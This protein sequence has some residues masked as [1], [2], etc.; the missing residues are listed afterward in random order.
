MLCLI[1]TEIV[2]YFGEKCVVGGVEASVCPVFK[3]LGFECADVYSFGDIV[4]R[5]L[6]ERGD[7]IEFGWDAFEQGDEFIVPA[8]DSVCLGDVLFEL[9]AGEDCF[10]HGRGDAGVC[11]EPE[12]VGLVTAGLVADE[13]DFSWWGEVVLNCLCA[14]YRRD[15]SSLS[16]RRRGG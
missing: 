12:F 16:R 10:S 9:S 3:V 4:W 1:V 6:W 5:G 14:E 8:D 7:E 15:H 2:E 11:N 13:D